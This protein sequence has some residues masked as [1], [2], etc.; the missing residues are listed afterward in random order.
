MSNIVIGVEGLV[1]SGKTS[2][3]KELVKLLPNSIYI[4]AGYIYR[5]IVLAIAKNKV[6][7]NASNVNMLKVMEDLK[8]D[9]KIENN[10]AQIYIDGKKISDSE[11]ETMENSIGV[12]KIAS[13]FDNRPLF[14]F[15][16]NMVNNYK[17][18]YNVIFSGRDA[19]SMYPDMDIHLYVTASLESRA[20]RRFNQYNGKYSLEEIKSIINQRD[21]LHEKS[22]FNRESEKTVKLDLTDSKS[23]AES[24]LKAFNLL[25][26]KG[27]I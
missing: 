16:K 22:G 27:I 26:E 25:K 23:G 19:L 3:C 10:I 7:L 20:K 24:A 18:K 17:Q 15:A 13:E 2:M 1:A 12:S 4:D 6:N 5:G 14:E 21:M 9:F 11:I 8:V